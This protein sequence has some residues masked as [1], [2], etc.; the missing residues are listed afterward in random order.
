M[1]AVDQAKEAAVGAAPG[2]GSEQAE[3]GFEA[4]RIT[5]AFWKGTPAK[6]EVAKLAFLCTKKW[7]QALRHGCA[8]SAAQV[9][10]GA[11]RFA[12]GWGSYVER[13]GGEDICG[14]VNC[15]AGGELVALREQ[16][17][18]EQR[19]VSGKM[20]AV[21]IKQVQQQFLQ[22]AMLEASGLPRLSLFYMSH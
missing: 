3:T 1:E 11:G 22:E 2:N 8:S 7:R 5:L 17:A 15:C 4:A 21:Q 18:R 20:Q 10:T 13:V 19:S 9:R 12:G 14:A 6:V 16:A